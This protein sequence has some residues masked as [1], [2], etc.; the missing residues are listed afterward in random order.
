MK[1]VPAL[2][3]TG[4][5]DI[6]ITDDLG[7]GIDV[8][9]NL[10][11]TNNH[12]RIADLL[13]P[14]FQRIIGVLEA[15]ALLAAP[16]I[17]FSR[18]AVAAG[19]V[20]T[21]PFIDELN[22]FLYGTRRFLGGLWLQKDNAVDVELGFFEA[23]HR[24]NPSRVASNFLA[25]STSQADERVSTITFSRLEL[26]HVAEAFMTKFRPEMK[27]PAVGTP[28]VS[29]I[30]RALYLVQA[31]RSHRDLT[32]KVA[33]YCMCLEALFSTSPTE[34]AHKLAER[35]AYFVGRDAAARKDLYERTKA[36]YTV[37]STVLHGDQ[38]SKKQQTKLVEA[39][40]FCDQTLRQILTAILTIPPVE[41]VFASDTDNL[42]RWLLPG[43]R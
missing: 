4:L 15:Q 19:Q 37:R 42:E 28:R 3:V 23:P 29:R 11:I 35:V 26:E 24:A 6:E 21:S 14:H 41:Q 8:R 40:T 27:D 18:T 34:L 32:L 31:A 33:F 17:L 25:V 2:F 22:Q 5:L 1:Q 9:H 20:P 13:S 16:A 39:A 43:D 38:V 30:E 10:H 7:E 12:A 36:A